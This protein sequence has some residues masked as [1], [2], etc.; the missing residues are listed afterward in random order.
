M[1]FPQWATRVVSDP[2][3]VLLRQPSRLSALVLGAV[4][5]LLAD[6]AVLS[7]GTQ[8]G[9]GSCSSSRPGGGTDSSRLQRL[10]LRTFVLLWPPRI[11]LLLLVS[12]D[13]RCCSWPRP[14]SGFITG[15]TLPVDGGA[16]AAG[17]YMVEKYRRRKAAANEPPTAG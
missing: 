13:T 9:A 16:A 14:E 6:G 2:A 17:A 10:V 15:V 11:V 1:F 4:A 7:S 3:V 12:H 8:R 5:F